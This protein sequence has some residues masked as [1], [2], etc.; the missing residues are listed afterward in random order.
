MLNCSEACFVNRY[1]QSS[2]KEGLGVN[3]GNRYKAVNQ[4]QKSDKK[5]KR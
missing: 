3:M 1:N 5:W 4:F 2:F